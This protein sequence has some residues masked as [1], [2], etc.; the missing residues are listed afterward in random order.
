M[1]RE[2]KGLMQ[3]AL[4]LSLLSMPL[5]AACDD[6]VDGSAQAATAPPPPTVTVARPLVQ[7]LTEWD[8]FTGRFEAVEQ[9]DIRA[10]VQGYLES[11]HFAD[12]QIVEQG[13]LL[14]VIDQ[15]PFKNSLNIARASV[16]AAEAAYEQAQITEQRLLRLRDKN[17]PAFQRADYEDQVQSRL[18]AQGQLDRARA[19][20]AAAEL[21][22]SFTKVTA[23]VRGRISN[24]RA[25]VGNLVVSDTMLS[26]IVA[27]D[28]IYFTFDMSE[29]DFV[30][31]QRAVDRGELPSTR[32]DATTV[33][34]RLADEEGWPRAGRMNFVDNV[35]DRSAGTVRARA[36]VANPDYFLAP[37]QFGIVRIPGSPEY[38]AILVP[39]D[40]IVSDQARKLVL[41]VAPDGTVR[42]KEINPGPRDHGL[43]IVR[44]GLTA[45]DRIIVQGVTR[46]RPG[47]KVTAEDGA[48]E[49]PP[50]PAVQ[51]GSSN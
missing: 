17:S 45:E 24:R 2:G 28:P 46:A 19:E 29:A 5:L 1:R 15:R 34:I 30:A 43:R 36:I 18:Q 44:H 12:G 16:A 42:P 41:T 32:D 11:V 33:N 4:L 50:A 10:R 20:L 35:V 23:P 31:Y 40:A 37:G 49:L 21:D 3:P 13:Q 47:A 26:T 14:F 7:R 38:D 22:L 48:V 9:V 39:D 27:L 25:D 51:V 8:E 6:A